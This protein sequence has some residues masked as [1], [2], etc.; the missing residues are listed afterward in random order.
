MQRK[1]ELWKQIPSCWF[2]FADVYDE[3][4]ET[5]PPGSCL[6]ECGSF[7]GQS[8]VYL[9]EA[10]KIADKGLRVYSVD[11]WTMTPANNPPMFDK[12][13]IGDHI[14]PEI[15]AQFHDSPFET[16]AH[17]VD[18][19]G[20]SPDPLR[21]LRMDAIEAADLFESSDCHIHFVFLDD[22]HEYEHVSKELRAWWFNIN[23]PYGFIAGHDWTEEFSG[24]Q[25]AV[26]EFF[27]GRNVSLEIKGRTWIVRS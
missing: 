14:E 10:A 23:R 15:H 8:A 22:D 12:T 9:A 21:I 27:D 20:L 26:E 11:S 19:T 3:A 18:R 16:Y 24:V 7:W 5:A 25:R 6:I 2:D 4:V 1:P 17:F 13:L